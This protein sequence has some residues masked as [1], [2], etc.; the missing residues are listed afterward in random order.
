[1]IPAFWCNGSVGVQASLPV[2]AE[3]AALT[4]LPP[5]PQPGIPAEGKEG[6][7]NGHASAWPE[8]RNLPSCLHKARSRVGWDTVHRIDLFWFSEHFTLPLTTKSGKE[9]Q[10]LLCCVFHIFFNSPCPVDIV[11]SSL[12]GGVKPN[13]VDAGKYSPMRI[14]IVLQLSLIYISVIYYTFNM[15]VF[16]VCYCFL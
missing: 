7:A 4:C 13:L 1:M 6:M 16:C 10:D 14:V 9:V 12:P 3:V 11:L 2:A 15:I 5:C 8:V